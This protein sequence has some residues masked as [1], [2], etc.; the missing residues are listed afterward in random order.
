MT[1][2]EHTPTAPGSESDASP[3]S[4]A[5]LHGYVDR[6]LSPARLALVE[7]FLATHP[8]ERART[9]DWQQ[10]NEMMRGLLNPVLGEPVPLR[11][12][13]KANAVVWPWR[14]LAAGV[15]ISVVS[16]ARPGR[17]AARWMPRRHGSRSR[18]RPPPARIAG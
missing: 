12:P 10:Q 14:G 2:D 5:D 4:E 13:V 6:Q 3:I 8:E 1:M 9:R 7:Q 18:I 17:C 15:L 16:A 11:L